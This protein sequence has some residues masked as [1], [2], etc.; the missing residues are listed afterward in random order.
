MKQIDAFVDSVY[1]NVGGNRN[2]KELEELKEE[3]KTH[4][5]EAVHD[6]KQ[7]GTS[8]Q[9]AIE[10]AIERFGGETEMRS[11]VGQLF[12]AQTVF[13]KWV[14]YIAIA[15]LV[16]GSTVT[17][18]AFAMNAQYKNENSKIAATIVGMLTNKE[19]IPD[20]IQTE[21]K[22]LVQHTDQIS[23]V[24]IYKTKDVKSET[25]HGTSYFNHDAMPVYQY[26][27]SVWALDRIDYYYAIG[28]EWFVHLESNYA[29]AYF[30]FIL[31][32][33]IA[34]YAVLF[35]IWAT[36]N[37]YHH[38]RFHVGWIFVFALLNVIGYMVYRL[39]ERKPRYGT[40]G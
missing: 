25:E 8:E 14:L 22:K 9:E 18:L 27:R 23:Q 21:I 37:A 28:D 2:R 26:D 16:I 12:N 1:A 35:T 7:A 32:A 39:L 36:I 4:L 11:I 5:L 17:G 38:R 40:D 34:I 6:L 29:V 3:M 10:I 13:A 30:D 33:S 24:Q 15:F 20:D 19:V 31:T